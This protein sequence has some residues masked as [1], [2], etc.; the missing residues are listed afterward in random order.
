LRLAAGS[1]LIDAGT[2]VGLP[3]NGTA[4]DLGAFET[5]SVIPVELISFKASI[6]NNSI[7]LMWVTST[8]LNNRGFE[9]Q[10]K[11]NENDFTIIGFVSGTG[12]T[13]ENQNIILQ[14]KC[15]T[16]IKYI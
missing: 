14:T 11:L 1:D 4:P 3:F 16:G 8:E 5:G 10:K 12:T 13:T 7:L 9:V 15:V 6:F 2:N